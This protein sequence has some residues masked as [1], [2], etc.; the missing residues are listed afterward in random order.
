MPKK[1]YWIN[2]NNH[3]WQQVTPEQYTAEG[4]VWG[5]YS[6]EGGPPGNFGGFN[7]FGSIEAEV[8]EVKPKRRRRT[9]QTSV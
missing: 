4:A 9:K 1:T 2:K 5:Q 6:K 3:G 7:N 8:R